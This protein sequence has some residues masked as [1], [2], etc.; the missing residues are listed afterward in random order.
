ME[1]ILLEVKVHHNRLQRLRRKG[2][3]KMLMTTK[4][5]RRRS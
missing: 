3:K 4:A 5:R 2:R 1:E